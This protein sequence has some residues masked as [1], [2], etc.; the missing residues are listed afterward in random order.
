MILIADGGSTKAD[1]IALDKNKKEIFN[2]KLIESD[3]LMNTL[4]IELEKK[5]DEFNLLHN[6]YLRMP[7]LIEFQFVDLNLLTEE[8]AD[9]LNDVVDFKKL[10]EQFYVLEVA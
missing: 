1:W 10:F 7:N 8:E 3:I 5:N 9:F 2:Q 4:K 6:D